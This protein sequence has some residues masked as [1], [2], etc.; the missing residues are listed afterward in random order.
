[1]G[2]SRRLI[3]GYGLSRRRRHGLSRRSDLLLNRCVGFGFYRIRLMNGL[4]ESL[5]RLAQPLPQLRQL[6]RS[7]NDQHN[8]QD[9]DQL[10]KPKAPKH[11]VLLR[12]G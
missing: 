9:Q 1:L 7:E 12:K 10:C 5:D 6:P 11:N 2:G 3:H 4:L 8:D